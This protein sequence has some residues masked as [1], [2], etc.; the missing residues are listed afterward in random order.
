M[1][2]LQILC[3]LPRTLRDHAI[4]KL[5]AIKPREIADVTVKVASTV[6]EIEAAARILHDAYVARG[7]ISPHPSGVRVTPH[8]LLPT[9]TIFIAKRGDVVIGTMALILDG[10]L[11]LPMGKIYGEEIAV[12]RAQGRKLAEVGAL[13]V[14][15]GHRR[16]GISFL[17][18]K[19]MFRSSREILGVDD[20]VIS[21]HPD[22][23]VLY[24][25]ALLFHRIG[26]TRSYPGLNKTALAVALRLEVGTAPELYLRTFG[27]AKRHSNPYYMYEVHEETQLKLPAASDFLELMRQ[28][29]LQAASALARTRPDAFVDL[30]WKEW[31]QLR[32]LLP[33]VALPEPPEFIA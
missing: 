15:T 11:G 28:P 4:R 19:I 1:N 9:T 7:L 5:V 16:Q 2:T 17:L 27:K 10:P 31:Q 24:H 21:V 29:R 6:A 8:L 14:A 33:N 32:R 22:V 18:N 12:L 3:L 23:E 25:A 30:T 20:L 13:C 26:P